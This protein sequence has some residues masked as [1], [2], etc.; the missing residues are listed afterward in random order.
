MM[1]RISTV[2]S[3]RTIPTQAPPTRK[4]GCTARP[5]GVR[6][7]FRIMGHALMDNRHGLA[8]GGRVTQATGTA[9]REASEA[10]LKAKAKVSRRADHRRR[11]Q[12]LTI[13]PITS[14]ICVMPA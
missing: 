8:V 12:G 6:Q 14:P 2:R 1:A 9:E 3:V 4:A 11:R 7:S 13:P 10:M 5:L